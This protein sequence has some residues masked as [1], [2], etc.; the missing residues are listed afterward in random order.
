MPESY[1]ISDK[2]VDKLRKIMN[3][4]A[5]FKMTLELLKTEQRYVHGPISSPI[6]IKKDFQL[7]LDQHFP[8]PPKD[9]Q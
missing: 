5:E 9:K 3:N 7:L 6:I 4:E 2:V 1:D 8:L